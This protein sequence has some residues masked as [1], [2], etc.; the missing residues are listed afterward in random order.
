MANIYKNAF[1]DPSDTSNTVV[2]ATDS[3][4]RAIIQ[5]IQVTNESGSKVVRAYVFDASNSNTA[6]QVAYADITGPTICNLAKGPIILEESDTLVLSSSDTSGVSA[7][8]S[9][10]EVNRGLIQ[11]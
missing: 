2:Y 3:L 1:F 5:N 6:V 4:T 9:I 7:T 8:V 11:Q 10:L